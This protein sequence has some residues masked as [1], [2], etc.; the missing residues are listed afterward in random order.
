MNWELILLLILLVGGV[1]YLWFDSIRFF[2]RRRRIFS[3]FIKLVINKIIDT[4]SK[5]K[6]NNRQDNEGNYSPEPVSMGMVK[7]YNTL[8]SVVSQY[9]KENNDN[10][11]ESSYIGVFSVLRSHVNRIIKRLATKCKQNPTIG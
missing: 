7:T 11:N 3:L 4:L 6:A 10:N 5:Q 1:G 8:N 2:Y 9:H